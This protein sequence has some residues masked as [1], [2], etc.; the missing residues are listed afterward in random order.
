M[1]SIPVIAFVMELWTSG[2]KGP[3]SG[4]VVVHGPPSSSWEA[5]KS[6]DPR[7]FDLLMPAD[8]LRTPTARDGGRGIGAHCRGSIIGH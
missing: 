3:R 6:A 5:L 1:V 7:D 2:E 8:W 4:M